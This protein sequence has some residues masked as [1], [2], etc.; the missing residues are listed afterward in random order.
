MAYSIIITFQAEKTTRKKTNKSTFS[1]FVTY[2][3][4]FSVSWLYLYLPC[5]LST[6]HPLKRMVAFVVAWKYIWKGKS[7]HCSTCISWGTRLNRNRN[8]FRN[9]TQEV[10]GS[11]R[12]VW[13]QQ[14][15]TLC[16]FALFLHSKWVHWMT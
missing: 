10:Q 8:I 14:Y 7:Q 3:R 15:V 1:F 9:N 6:F 11:W 16:Q 13:L 2:V 12:S 5:Q 4:L